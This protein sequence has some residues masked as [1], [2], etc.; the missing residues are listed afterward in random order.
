MSNRIKCTD[1]K[2]IKASQNSKSAAEAARILGIKYDT[3]KKYATKLN[4]FSTNQSGKGIKKHYNFVEDESI[5][6]NYFNT[7][8]SKLKAYLVGYIAADG[9]IRDNSVN[10]MIQRKDKG[11]LIKICE[12]LNIDKGRIIDFDS[13][14]SGE[15]KKFPSCRLSICSKQ[16]VSDLNKYNIIRNKSNIDIDMFACIPDDYKDSWL[17]GYLDGNGSFAKRTY[18]QVNVISNH[19]TIQSIARYVESKYNITSNQCMSFKNGITT[20]LYYGTSK[21]YKTILN[22][23]LSASPYHI[24][25]K[26][27]TVNK[28]IDL[29]DVR[30]IIVSE[31]VQNNTKEIRCNFCIDCGKMIS[32]SSTRCKSCRSK[33][34]QYWK[35]QRPSRD[36]L[37][38]EIRIKPFLQI[39]KE[40]HVTDNAVRKWCKGYNLPFKKN[41]IKKY[42]DSE[43]EM[44]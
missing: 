28:I 43:W 3:Y 37:K 27:E 36:I 24:Q 34:S 33:Q 13:Y 25:R 44:I 19:A 12:E 20:K 1:E 42:S 38:K 29:I 2:I 21:T 9:G 10:F 7:I 17:V 40:Y 35:V 15:D 18:G 32:A 30:K 31:K 6:Y 23:Y 4:V 11:I 8:D 14:R 39:G 26:L 41:D 22:D 5:N 16:I